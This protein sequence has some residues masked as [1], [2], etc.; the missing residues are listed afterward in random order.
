M[1]SGEISEYINQNT[2][3]Y[4]SITPRSIQR[5]VKSAS[6]KQYNQDK[7][8]KIGD[9][10]RLAVARGRVKWPLKEFKYKRHRLSSKIRYAVLQR[11]NFRCVKCGNT[12]QTSI[13]EVD[14]INPI[15]R[16]GLSVMDNLETLCCLCNKGKQLVENER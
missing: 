7:T 1:S 9:A 3:D 8:R 14:H 15:C 6:I 12:A 10:F 2:P 5:T 11:D 13:L 16:G 4:V